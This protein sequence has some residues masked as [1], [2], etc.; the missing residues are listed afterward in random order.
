MPAKRKALLILVLVALALGAGCTTPQGGGGTPSPTVAQTQEET[1]ATT[2]PQTPVVTIPPGPVVTTPPNYEVIV[3]VM[4][5]PNTANPYIT[6]AFRGGTGQLFLS[7]ITVTVAR[8]DGQ[9]DQAMIPQSG[10]GQYAVG[11]SVRIPGTSGVDRVMVVVTILG[12]DYKIY[13]ENLGFNSPP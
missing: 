2:V 11:D 5:N 1:P 3:Q 10:Q 9:V 7:R 8:S 6:A 12:V 13:D 4:K